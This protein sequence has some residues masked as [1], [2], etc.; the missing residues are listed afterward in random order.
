[1]REGEAPAEPSSPL[2]ARQEPRPP[3]YRLGRSLALPTKPHAPNRIVD[4]GRALDLATLLVLSLPF[5]PG[6]DREVV[7]FP[8]APEGVVLAQRV[9][10][11]LFRHQDAAQVRVPLEDDPVHVKDL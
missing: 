2:K 10:R 1:M 4:K 3:G 8:A 11:E 7:P 6:D 5:R 9:G